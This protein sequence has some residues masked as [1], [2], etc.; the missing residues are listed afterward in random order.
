M[1]GCHVYSGSQ[2]TFSYIPASILELTA[3]LRRPYNTRLIR[4]AHMASRPS[5]QQAVHDRDDEYG[6]S[7]ARGGE[8]NTHTWMC[9]QG[10]ACACSAVDIWGSAWA[11]RPTMST[12][13]EGKG[14]TLL[15]PTFNQPSK[16]APPHW[17]KT[18]E[19]TR[20]IVHKRSLYRATSAS[21]HG[22]DDVMWVGD[23]TGVVWGG[24]QIV[25]SS[26]QWGRP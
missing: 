7:Q 26:G 10:A 24:D 17:H 16:R 11:T 8:I 3:L 12:G 23:I 25:Q 20:F 1:A 19:K 4:C 22:G 21:H 2:E 9:E 6:P 5:V 13:R 14:L 18:F 15:G